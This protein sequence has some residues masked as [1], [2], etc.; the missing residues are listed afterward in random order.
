MKHSTLQFFHNKTI[1]IIFVLSLITLIPV[2]VSQA[3]TEAGSDQVAGFIT[4]TDQ[5]A[6]PLID[7]L[8]KQPVDSLIKW[9]TEFSK[10]EGDDPP[11]VA[12]WKIHVIS[13]TLQAPYYLYV[14]TN[15]N[16]D[17]P[18]PLMVWLHGGVNRPVFPEKDSTIIEHPIIQ[19][20][21]VNGMLLLFPMA[22]SGCLWWD[23]MGIANVI[24]QIRETKR[25]YNVDD[26]AVFLGGFSDGASGAF[27]I[28]MLNPSDFA[29][30]F[31]WSGH[32]AVG[33]LVGKT[34]VY[35][36]NLAC[37][38]LFATN[39][40]ADRLY[41]A[42]R[43]APLIQL[44]IE[45]GSE[46]YF[47]SYDTA[48]HNY[49][50]MDHEWVPFTRRTSQI[51]RNARNPHI[52]WETADIKYSSCDWLEITAL[53]TGREA[54]EWH[55]D[56]NYKLTNDRVTIGFNADREWEGDG[57][58]IASI[59]QDS[60]LPAFN[61]GLKE[62][63]IFVGLDDIDIKDLES[64]GKAKS[65][66]K[67]GD[68]VVM[69][70]IRDDKVLSFK[71]QFP[72]QS[73]F[74]AFARDSKSGAVDAMRIGNRFEIKASRIAGIKLKLTPD[75]IRFDQNVIVNVNGKTVFNDKVTASSQYMLEEYIRSRDRKLLYVAAIDIDV[76]P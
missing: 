36:P 65:T 70:V 49:G 13:D 21:E 61:A 26:D 15:Y 31:P 16:P 63:D 58:R 39:G 66:K 50:Y 47:T 23:D 19:Q 24:W 22:K 60:T 41:P 52:L 51:R 53:D 29:A 46:L 17:K 48:G 27:H 55:R 73:K 76:E 57:V 33:S 6:L 8:A 68:T 56:V 14:P 11:G 4:S 34:P 38:P 32:M 75:M 25:L 28:A 5:E 59:S 18:T 10:F 44:A 72:L 67:R 42:D 1:P 7:E 35:V 43:M 62:G 40:G 9:I 12:A 3:A 71:S 64:L 45:N 2:A 37:R 69:K 54:E 30:F 20:A 74:D